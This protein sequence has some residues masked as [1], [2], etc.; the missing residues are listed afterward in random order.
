M[1]KFWIIAKSRSL[2]TYAFELTW[3]EDQPFESLQKTAHWN[4]LYVLKLT[5]KEDP[6]L[7]RCEKLI[8]LI[9]ARGLAYE[10]VDRE[11]TACEKLFI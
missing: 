7:I 9:L 4:L 5:L 11:E 6:R 10:G 3:K 2:D 1:I 8:L